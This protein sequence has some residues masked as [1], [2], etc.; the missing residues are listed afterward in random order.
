MAGGDAGHVAEATGGQAQQRAV[1]FGAVGRRIHQRGRDEMR[2]VRHD[3][4]QPV[5]VGGRKDEDV[6]PQAGHDPLQ[7]VEGLQLGRRRRREGPHRPHE[8]V[9]VGAAQAGLLG[10][11]HRD[12]RR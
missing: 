10:P 2:H 5:V 4:H 11:G 12:G 7:P 6:G 3:G 8:E 9:G 1:L